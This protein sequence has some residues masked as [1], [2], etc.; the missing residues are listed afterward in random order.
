M[1][2]CQRRSPNRLAG[3]V[4]I[5]LPLSKDKYIPTKKMFEA[6]EAG[7]SLCKNCVEVPKVSG[8]FC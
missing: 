2:R 5:R 6:L 1:A 7:F 4:C 3:V 8:V